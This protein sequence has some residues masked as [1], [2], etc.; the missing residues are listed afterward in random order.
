M[1]KTN[2]LY[3]ISSLPQLCKS[4]GIDVASYNEAIK[5]PYNNYY[6][7]I[8]SKK[9]LIEEPN[10]LL[11]RILRK[12]LECL[13]VVELPTYCYGLSKE[14][15]TIEN[16]RIHKNMVEILNF[17][18]SHYYPN[19]KSIYVED[20]FK[21]KLK[22]SDE[23]LEAVIKMTTC[24]GH[25]S[26]GSP[27]SPIL[28][29]LSHEGI[30][31]RIYQKMSENDVNMSLYYDDLSF[32]ANKHLGSW[33]YDYCKKSLKQHGLW[34]K[35]SKIKHFGYRGGWFTGVHVSQSGKLSAPHKLH[36]KVVKLLKSKPIEDMNKKE[37]R[38]LIGTIAYLQQFDSKSFRV[39]KQVAQKMLR[40]S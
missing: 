6:K 33:I 13:S 15:G 28:A 21:N 20:F 24:N 3:K 19:T 31:N 8:N 9:R 37:L 40:E 36:Y 16:A 1:Y 30:F 18:I 2:P 35:T 17:D 23:A 39:T 32:S 34:I 4:L 10:N 5:K 29:F 14:H 27:T 38:S 11:K 22:M 26:T 7:I 12:L 25:L